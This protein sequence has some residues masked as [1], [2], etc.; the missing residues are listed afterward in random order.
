M[1]NK[2]ALKIWKYYYD[3]IRGRPKLRLTE[4]NLNKIPRGSGV[5]VI[6]Y[7]ENPIYVG[8]S[9]KM[10][11]R[12]TLYHFSRRNDVSSSPFRKNLKLRKKIKYRDMRE[13]ILKNCRFKFV[14]I[15][16]YDDSRLLEAM[17]IRLWRKK[18]RLFNDIKYE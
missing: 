4:N 17:L 10:H 15:A 16:N 13:W 6:Y 12:L 18:Y 14:R 9:G 3:N 5:Y 11:S 8:T 1:F 7:R 2:I